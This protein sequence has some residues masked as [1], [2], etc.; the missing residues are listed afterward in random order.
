MVRETVP[1]R[2]GEIVDILNDNKDLIAEATKA[3]M[4]KAG[5]GWTTIQP[6]V[7]RLR[8]TNR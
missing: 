1:E 3:E 7:F 4:K 5:T 8:A 6:T 2:L